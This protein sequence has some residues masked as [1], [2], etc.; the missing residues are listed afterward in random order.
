MI[1]RLKWFRSY[2]PYQS[3]TNQSMETPAYEGNEKKGKENNHWT[4]VDDEIKLLF[5]L[6]NV[7]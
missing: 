2:R 3:Y 6:S 4:L 1:L 7:M 5:L